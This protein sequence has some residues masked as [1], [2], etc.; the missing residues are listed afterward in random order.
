MI[1]GLIERDS[2]F[3]VPAYHPTQQI[4]T[5]IRVLSEEHSQVIGPVY[6]KLLHLF[7]E[8]SVFLLKE[9]WPLFL[10]GVADEFADELELVELVG[11]LEDRET[12]LEQLAQDA[13]D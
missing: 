7:P 1:E 12:L 13:A 10:G 5:T 4:N 2:P 3:R 11:A 9:L 8:V 6:C